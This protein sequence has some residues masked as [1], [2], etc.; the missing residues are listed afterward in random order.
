MGLI[1]NIIFLIISISLKYLKIL[2]LVILFLVL[3][4]SS[5][6]N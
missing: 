2:F 4:F 1:I 3:D 5:K 6:K